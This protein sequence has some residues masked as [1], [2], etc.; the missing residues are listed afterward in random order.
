MSPLALLLAAV[1]P[2]VSASAGDLPVKKFEKSGTLEALLAANGWTV[3]AITGLRHVARNE[4]A[5]SDTIEKLIRIQATNPS[6]PPV[7]FYVYNLSSTPG[8]YLDEKGRKQKYVSDTEHFMVFAAKREPR[9]EPCVSMDVPA[10]GEPTYL[11]GNDIYLLT[12]V[13]GRDALPPPDPDHAKDFAQARERLMGQLTGA[14]RRFVAGFNGPWQDGMV[15]A[16]CP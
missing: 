9:H 16:S 12:R 1:F 6:F 3:G 13:F 5:H 8:E 11:Y 14:T 2:A 10:K 4:S 7:T 15:L